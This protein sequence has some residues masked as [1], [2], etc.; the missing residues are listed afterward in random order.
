MS[1][2]EVVNSYCIL[3]QIEK[4]H[5]RHFNFDV[6]GFYDIGPYGRQQRK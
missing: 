4:I 6:V 5:L 3:R 2:G 1:I